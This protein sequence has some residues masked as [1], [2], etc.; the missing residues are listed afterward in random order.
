MATRQAAA[1]GAM[2][3][4]SSISRSVWAP[5]SGKVSVRS[6]QPVSFPAAARSLSTTPL[7]KDILVETKGKVGVI[8]LNRPKALN[9]LNS[10]LINEVSDALEKFDA[11]PAVNAVVLT[12]SEKSFAAG[13]DIKEMA[14]KPFIECLKANFVGSWHAIGKARKPIIAAVNG[15]AFG[16]GCEVAMMCDI[17]YAGDNA[18]FGQP[19]ITIGT[20]PGAGGTQR[21]IRSIGKSRA[22]EMILTG[23]QIDAQEALRL[24]LVSKVFPKGETLAKAIET[25]EKIAS[26]SQPHTMLA[27]EA[28]NQANELG[29]QQGLQYEQRAFWSTFATADQKEGMG[30]FV[31]KRKPDYKNE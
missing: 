20:I 5:S 31:E 22:M 19:E 11:N 8:T 24:G 2:R 17:I 23:E 16:G 15:F 9:A 1:V 28:V 3:S 18:K 10:N 12:G 4:V 30:A 7:Y 26:F 13:A 25:A 27:K 14:N 29:L 6:T 21:L